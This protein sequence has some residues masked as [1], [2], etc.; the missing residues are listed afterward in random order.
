MILLDRIRPRQTGDN[1]EPTGLV[2]QGFRFLRRKKNGSRVL[3]VLENAH[4]L[5]EAYSTLLQ[6]HDSG[7]D[8]RQLVTTWRTLQHQALSLA[9]GRDPLCELCRIG[10]IVYLTECLEPLP[11]IGAFHENGSRKLTMLIDECDKLGYWQTSPNLLLW[12]SVLGGYTARGSF[13]RRWYLEQLRGSPIQLSEERWEEVLALSQTFL[14]LRGQQG[15]GCRQ[16]WK[17]ACAWLSAPITASR[18]NIDAKDSTQ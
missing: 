7:M 15:E 18:Y 17:E 9:H 1:S 4:A 14:P 16:F 11:V 3:A 2:C 6:G 12:V 10:V 8:F 13:L 5:V